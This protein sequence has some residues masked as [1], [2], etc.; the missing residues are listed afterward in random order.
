[1]RHSRATHLLE[2]GVEL[3]VVGGRLGHVGANTTKRYAGTNLGSKKVAQPSGEA[4][5]S[6]AKEFPG[7]SI[8]CDDKALLDWL[9]SL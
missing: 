7:K 9:A 2:G 4:P 6:A 8:W 3:N 1:M 5:V